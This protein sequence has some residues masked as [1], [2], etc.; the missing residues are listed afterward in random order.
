MFELKLYEEIKSILAKIEDKEIRKAI[1]TKLASNMQI[2]TKTTKRLREEQLS[3]GR[4]Q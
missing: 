2:Y 4:E 1:A 3:K